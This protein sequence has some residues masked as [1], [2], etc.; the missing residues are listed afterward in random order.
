MTLEQSV[1]QVLV[2]ELFQ[3]FK[4][5]WSA[6]KTALVVAILVNNIRTRTPTMDRP[7]VISS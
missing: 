7:W 2:Q 5:A 4:K 1:E 3:I 6:G